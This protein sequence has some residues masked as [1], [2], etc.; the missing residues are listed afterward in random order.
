MRWESEHGPVVVEM[1]DT[2]AGFEMVSRVDDVMNESRKR[3]E[4]A[5][6]GVRGMAESALDALRDV[7]VTPDTIELEFG[8][9]LNVAAG[10]VIARTALEGQVK[11]RV[12]WSGAAVEAAPGDDDEE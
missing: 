9:K 6:E 12:V 10:A 4:D 5:M 11:V 7:S 8:L 2:D 1:D 3:L